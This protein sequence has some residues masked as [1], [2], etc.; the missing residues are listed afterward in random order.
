MMTAVASIV[1][2]VVIALVGV[3]GGVSAITP[4]ANSAAK[5]EQVVSYNVR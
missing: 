4:K 2:G 5:S 1:T 3:V